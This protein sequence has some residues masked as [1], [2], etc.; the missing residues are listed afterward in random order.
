MPWGD[1]YAHRAL[2]HLVGASSQSVP[3]NRF[4]A[5]YTSAPNADGT[6]GTEVAAGDY[7]RVTAASKLGSAASRKIT[8]T[9]AFSFTTSAGSAWGTITH[10]K[11]MDAS[12]AGTCIRYG[13]ISPSIVVGLA[14]PCVIPIGQLTFEELTT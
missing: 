7:A 9:A 2:D 14:S 5:L 4:L 10:F 1:T 13:T 3:S 11:L 8:N 12:T 6:G